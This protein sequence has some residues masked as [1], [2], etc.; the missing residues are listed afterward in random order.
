MV[1]N[2]SVWFSLSRAPLPP[3]FSAEAVMR[4]ES[5][6]PARGRGGRAGMCRWAGEGPQGSRAGCQLSVQ[7]AP[8]SRP[9][10]GQGP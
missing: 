10:R 9:L 4:T 3:P 2:S 7:L 8:S 1:G 5:E 6:D